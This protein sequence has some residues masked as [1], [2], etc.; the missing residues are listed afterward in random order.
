MTVNTAL[1]RAVIYRVRRRLR[2]APAVLA[3]FASTPVLA[4]QDVSAPTAPVAVGNVAAQAQARSQAPTILTHDNREPA[5]AMLDKYLRLRLEVVRG[6]WRPE[7]A[8]GPVRNVYAFAEEGKAP[9][10]PGPL[11]RVPEGVDVQVS[12]RNRLSE[13][14]KIHGFVTR[15]ASND[16][17]VEIGPG[18]QREFRFRV[19]A[20]GTYYYWG[21]TSAPSFGDRVGEDS[22]LSGALIV[23]PAGGPAGPDRIFLMG[24][25]LELPAPATGP[26]KISL[27]INGR[28]W[29]HT[30]GLS[31]P[32]G[33]AAEWRVIN[34]SAAPH[35]MHLHGTFYTVESRGTA[36]RDTVYGSTSRRLVTTELMLA[37]TTMMMRWVPDRVGN[38]LFHCHLLAHV[39]GTMRAGDAATHAV[40]DQHEEHDPGRA[41]AG[42]VLGIVV[43]SGDETAAPDLESHERRRLTLHVRESPAR[44]GADPGYGFSLV[45]GTAEPPPLASG[46]E[47]SPPIILT[48][49]VP[50]VIGVSNRIHD[51][52]SIHW[53]GI[54]LE[55]INDG[56]PG[57]SGQSGNVMPSVRPNE[58]YDV[59]FTPPRA[60]TFI[61]HTHGHGSRQLASGV[62]GPLIVLD[63]GKTFDPA[64][65]HIIL[66]GGSGPGRPTI[67]VN[68]STNPPPLDVRAGIRHRFRLINITPNFNARVSLR[69]DA[70]L[71]Q[72][73]AVAKDGADLPPNQS[74]MRLA[75]QLVGIGETYDF[76]IQPNAPGE[77]R[78]EVLRAGFVTTMLVRVVR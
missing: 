53:H 26:R 37:G 28:S 43:Q 17:F 39:S 19:G 54:E 10:I 16:E 61:Y 77:L 73:R 31:L 20:P 58:T 67:E 38:W 50:V 62:Y 2:A 23:D 18:S 68:R 11:I 32:F 21:R 48:K 4:A 22:Q 1:T 72:W 3:V 51:A 27:V 71:V 75:S 44:Y 59:Q 25:W 34:A 36:T 35:P 66:L 60:G 7:G 12:V 70:G 29:P 55:S 46:A 57:W 45:D 47:L 42:L 78:L 69:G 14:V 13:P 24:E 5:G 9:H 8:D 56:V 63:S 65:D 64:T 41:M 49:G 15:P 6:T 52:L 74:T 33:L 40:E 76:E 30:E